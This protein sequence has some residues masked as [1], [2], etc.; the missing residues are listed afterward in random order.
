MEDGHEKL[1]KI[2]FRISS[3]L[4]TNKLKNLI[5]TLYAKV[6]RWLLYF[7]FSGAKGMHFIVYFFPR[8]SGHIQWKHHGARYL[9]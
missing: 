6:L 5:N 7:S 8:K 9:S 4:L 3:L 1:Y 2:C